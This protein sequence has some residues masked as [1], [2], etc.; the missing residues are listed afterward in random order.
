MARTQ[1]SEENTVRRQLLEE[2]LVRATRHQYL[3]HSKVLREFL[4]E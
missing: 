4:R 3:C 1:D 2:F